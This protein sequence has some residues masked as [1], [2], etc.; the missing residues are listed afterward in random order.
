MKYLLIT[1]NFKK[2]ADKNKYL[3]LNNFDKNNFLK[4]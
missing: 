2:F 3:N 1:K 4:I